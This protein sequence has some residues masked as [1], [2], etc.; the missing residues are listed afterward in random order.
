MYD[1][2]YGKHWVRKDGWL[3]SGKAFAV[4][5]K[6]KHLKYLTL[7]AENAIDI[8]LFEKEG[9]LHRNKNKELEDVFI[10]EK[11]GSIAQKIYALV[12]P[13]LKEAIFVGKL[14]NILN[15]VEDHHTRDIDPDDDTISLRNLQIRQKFKNKKDHYRLLQEF[16]FDLINFDIVENML[17]D[18]DTPLLRSLQKVFDYQQ[19]TNFLLF[20]TIPTENI[21]ENFYSLFKERLE[22]NINNYDEIRQA[23]QERHDNIDFNDIDQKCKIAIGFAKQIIIPYSQQYNWQCKHHGIFIY[24]NNKGRKMLNTIIEVSKGQNENQYIQ[25]I[26]NVIK[27]MPYFM[28]YQ[29]TYPEEIVNDLESVIAYREEI[30]LRE[31]D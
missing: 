10:C 28:P 4:K 16:P 1:K 9:L 2:Y 22:A 6:K 25:D 15:F 3:P 24:E 26:I 7:C 18:L 5:Y 14:E 21:N 19:N 31:T 29:E 17:R 13:P 12:R 11:D 20:V 30:R 8:F 23:Y 27:T